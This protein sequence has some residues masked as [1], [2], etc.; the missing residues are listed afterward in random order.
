MQMHDDRRAKRAA[1]GKPLG[2]IFAGLLAFSGVFGAAFLQPAR[3]AD[4][5]SVVMSSYGFLYLPVLTARELGYFDK[6]GIDVT[7]TA[8]A[9]GSKALAAVTGGGADIYVGAPSSALHARDHGAPVTVFGADMTQYS[10][11]IAVRRDWAEKHGITEKSSYEDKLKALKGI[12]I[13]V[14]S[15]GSGTD[16]LVRFLAKQAGLRPDRDLTITALGSGQAMLAAFSQNRIQG[17]THSAP[18][19]EEAAK[20]HDGVLLFN[21]SAGE[22]KPLDGFLYVA[23]I[24]REDWLSGHPDLA[25]RFLRA[26]Q[27]A[28][29]TL[30][31]PKETV[32]AMNAVHAKYHNRTDMKFYQYVWNNTTNAFPKSIELT[33]P[34]MQRVADFAN[35]FEKKPLKPDTLAKTWTN[36]YAAKA[37][38]KK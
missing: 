13:G 34:A 32:K 28:L 22:V 38:S 14:T 8:T 24:A 6:E 37:I 35:E 7:V 15:A 10:S 4:H 21:F 31:D 26:V 3:A 36:E 11:N 33:A 29:D 16:Q 12:T 9:G 18:D 27:H 1:A 23:L 25:V 2:L 17:F 20:N 5:V 19:A 30:H